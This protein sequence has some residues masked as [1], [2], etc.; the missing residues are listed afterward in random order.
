MGG[1]VN[2]FMTIGQYSKDCANF[3]GN[4][5]LIRKGNIKG[6]ERCFQKEYKK[7]NGAPGI[8]VF[9]ALNTKSSVKIINNQVDHSLFHLWAKWFKK[10]IEVSF[11]NDQN[12]KIKITKSKEVLMFLY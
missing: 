1:R 11:T 12:N 10:R 8:V 6:I 7:G 5:V 2:K 4:C 3:Y 9:Y